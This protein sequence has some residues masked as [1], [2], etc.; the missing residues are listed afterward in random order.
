[1]SFETAFRKIF[2]AGYD[3][4]IVANSDYLYEVE[5]GD[6]WRTMTEEQVIEFANNL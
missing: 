4:Q 6:T 2:N 3:I 5:I 1:M